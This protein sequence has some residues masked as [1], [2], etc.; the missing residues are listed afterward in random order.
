MKQTGKF[1]EYCV[2][3]NHTVVKSLVQNKGSQVI[4]SYSKVIHALGQ[5]NR[6]IDFV[7]TGKRSGL[8]AV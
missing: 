2:P 7:K 1:C 4:T 3:Q 5:S 8:Y 6:K